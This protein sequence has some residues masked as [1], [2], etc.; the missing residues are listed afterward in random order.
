[1]RAFVALE[2]NEPSVLEGLVAMQRRLVETGGDLKLVERQNLHFTVRFLGEISE[3]EASEAASRLKRLALSAPV[4]ELKGL[5]AFPNQN[6]PRVLW[7]G[8]SHEQE[9][10][11]EP[12]ALAVRTALDGIG[13]REDRPFA[14]H[15]TLARLRS[16]KR[17]GALT[18]LLRSEAERSF[19][20]ARLSGLKLK[21][22]TLTRQGPVYTDLGVYPLA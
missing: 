16:E 9:G 14:A 22:S 5:G 7:V 13:E 2:F 4:V 18:A 20:T 8:V 10:L 3:S 1:L 15:V 21:S 12:I 11:V 19:G 6:R 17:S